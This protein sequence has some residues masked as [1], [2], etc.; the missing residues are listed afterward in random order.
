MKL[1][2][3]LVAYDDT[4]VKLNKGL[5]IGAAYRSFDVGYVG[6]KSKSNYQIK[7]TVIR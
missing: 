4:S 5:W 6:M 7:Q 2:E 1:T 3:L